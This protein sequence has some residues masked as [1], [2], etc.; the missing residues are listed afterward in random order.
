MNALAQGSRRNVAGLVAAAVFG[1]LVATASPASSAVAP[2]FTLGV[3]A[4]MVQE[5]PRLADYQWSGR[6]SGTWGAQAVVGVGRWSGGLR[7]LT[8]GTTQSLESDATS[9]VRLNR[10][11]AIGRTRMASFAG[12][13]LEAGMGLGW[14]RVSWDPDQTTV[15]TPGGP[16]DVEF[17][18]IDE[19]VFSAGLMAHR[20]LPGLLRV[21]LELEHHRLALD[22]AHRDG[23]GI[24]EARESF[25]GYG[26]RLELA[27]HL[28]R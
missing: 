7:W 28:G 13:E 27:R 12:I 26:V 21:G 6:A 3:L 4:G 10:L 16:I 8:N 1:M 2:R 18:P 23:S 20:E 24:V 11:E 5:D 14:A 22:T 19:L 9:V 17:A 25:G 15:E